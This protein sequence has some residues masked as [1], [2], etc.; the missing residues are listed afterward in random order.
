MNYEAKA[1]TSY[2]E[3]KDPVAFAD[4]A[5]AFGVVVHHKESN[6]Y[7]VVL[8]EGVPSVRED[9]NGAFEEISFAEELSTHLKDGW[10]AVIMEIGNEGMRYMVGH[11]TAINSTGQR[12]DLDL[13]HIY[14]QA[15]ALGCVTKAE[16]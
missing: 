4:W 15:T 10:A 8:E 9:D 11:A 5:Q 1:R 7:A 13:G 6:R 12:L 2:F 16:Y 14:D 3:V